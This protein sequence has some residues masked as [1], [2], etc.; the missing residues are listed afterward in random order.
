M[1]LLEVR[2]S[3]TDLMQAHEGLLLSLQAA[4]EASLADPTLEVLDEIGSLLDQAQRDLAK[5]RSGCGAH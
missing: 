2:M 1:P 5:C 4:Q 3:D